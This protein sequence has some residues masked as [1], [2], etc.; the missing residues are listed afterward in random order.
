[1]PRVY[2]FGACPVWQA[3]FPIILVKGANIM[4]RGFTLIELLVVIAIIAILAAILF[5]VFAKAREKARQSSCLSNLRQLGTA[6]I[7]Y[8]QDYDECFPGRYVANVYPDY[9]I[10]LKTWCDVL[11]PYLKSV[12]IFVCPSHSTDTLG[13]GYNTAHVADGKCLATG[14]SMT[15]ILY[16][17]Q[18]ITMGDTSSPYYCYPPSNYLASTGY[19]GF[20]GAYLYR[21]NDG[22]NVVHVDGHAKW[23][24]LSTLYNNG[25]N[26]GFYDN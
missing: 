8:C 22:V 17:A 2:C 16:P 9:G 12:Q 6:L 11:A 10:N 13:Y 15:D 24:K 18:M 19:T 23:Y 5:P 26:S 21:H 14:G 20:A 25:V 7:S 1:V 4:R 3:G